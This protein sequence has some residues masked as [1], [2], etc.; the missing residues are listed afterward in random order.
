MRAISMRKGMFSNH[1][2]VGCEYRSRPLFSVRQHAEAQ[3]RP[4]GVD[5]S[6][7]FAPLLN[8]ARQCFGQTESTLHRGQQHQTA[9]RAP[10]TTLPISY[11]HPVL[12][13][14]V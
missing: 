2:A 3:V 14:A 5:R 11:G 12:N 1:L 13:M 10:Y 4:E 9:I 8:T 6:R 7:L